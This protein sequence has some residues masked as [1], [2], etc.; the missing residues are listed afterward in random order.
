[1]SQIASFRA[2][3]S[4]LTPYLDDRAVTEIAIN[5]PGKIWV[6]RQGQRFM[7]RVEIPQ[8]D[9]ALLHSLAQVTASFSSQHTDLA[10]PLLSAT[11]PINLAEDVAE[12]E[13][14]GY[15]VQVA[16]GPVVEN[17]TIAL[18]IRKP[19]L[20]D[21]GLDYYRK[22]GAFATTNRTE[23]MEVDSGQQLA[24]LHQD[25]CWDEFL[26]QAVQARKNIVISAGTNAGKTTLLNALL[27]EIPSAERVVTIEDA[28][29]VRAVQENCLH[30]LYSRGG[31]GT[32]NVTAVDLL[33]AT[34]RLAP[35]RAIMGELRG[36]EAYAYLELLNSGHA[37]SIT[38][39]HADSPDLMFGRL[40]QMVMR[41]GTTMVS[42]QIIEYAR[43]LI[44][45]VVQCRRGADGCRFVSE[46]LY[47]PR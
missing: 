21:V 26:R 5:G 8:L 41:F 31:Q 7:D 4:L 18:C 25:G 34:L 39:I 13:R 30:L 32:A 23:T 27:K 40:A 43:L 19:A 46:I 12:S 20:L 28:R 47:L 14:G 2:K 29:E 16:W 24:H 3:L 45:V 10:H 37:G 9:Y 36:A 6:S 33:E 22:Q 35:D 15:R 11:I 42:G 38:T 17:K 1:M 44:D